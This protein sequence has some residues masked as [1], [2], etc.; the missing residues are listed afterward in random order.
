MGK[1]ILLATPVDFSKWYDPMIVWGK[2]F[3]VCSI[4]SFFSI[5]PGHDPVLE[6]RGIRRMLSKYN[7]IV[8][9]EFVISIWCNS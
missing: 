7:A 6:K 4:V 3:D 2:V 8:F 9:P 5:A 1:L